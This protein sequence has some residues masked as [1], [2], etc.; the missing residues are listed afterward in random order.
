[1]EQQ[2]SITVLCPTYNEENYI[3]NILR[4]F[5]ESSPPNKELYIIDGG[6]TDGTVISPEILEVGGGLKC[7]KLAPSEPQRTF[8]FARRDVRWAAA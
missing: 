7:G 6:S 3:E 2:L 8:E 5:T 1:M 4:F